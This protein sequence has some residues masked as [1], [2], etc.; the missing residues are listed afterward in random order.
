VWIRRIRANSTASSTLRRLG[1]RRLG[2]SAA[3]GAV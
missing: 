2:F 1:E 3:L